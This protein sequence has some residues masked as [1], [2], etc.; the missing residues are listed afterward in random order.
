MTILFFV[1]FIGSLYNEKL[2]NPMLLLVHVRI[3]MA[4][5]VKTNILNSNEVDI[6]RRLIINM[7]IN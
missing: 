7:L 3:L 6:P 2:I 5:N 1:I 4:L